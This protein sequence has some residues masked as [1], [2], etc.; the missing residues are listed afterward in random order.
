MKLGIL[1]AGKMVQ[2]ALPTLQSLG[3]EKMYLLSRSQSEEKA[4]SL[5]GKHGLD[6]VYVDYD[7][8]LASDVDAVY[9]ALPNLL[10][11]DYAKAALLAGKHVLVEKPAVTRGEQWDE[12]CAL[13]RE[14]GLA[15]MEAMTV[16]ALPAFQSLRRQVKKVG[17][18]RQAIFTYPQ[19][20]SR[21]DDFLRGKVH[22]VF[23]PG[24]AGGALMDL[25]VYNLH[26]LLGLFGPPQA[27]RYRAEVVRG[28]DVNGGLTLDYEKFHAVAVAAKDRGGNQGGTIWGENGVL[29]FDGPVGC[30][31]RFTL[32]PAGGKE[33]NYEFPAD[34]LLPEFRCFMKAVETGDHREL[35]RLAALTAQATALMETAR[36]QAGIHF[37]GD[38]DRPFE[39]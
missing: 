31:A 16:H 37:P 12:L 7:A 11:Y 25:N 23:D 18:I 4:R 26:A 29:H 24:Q 35:D 30:L 33:K 9:I 28:I 20:S 27:V 5:A 22:P 1:G 8:L 14:R 15:L 34:R 2:A 3:L 13:A 19:R 17:D 36:A 38:K 6:G 39:Q 32:T 10:H 21:Y